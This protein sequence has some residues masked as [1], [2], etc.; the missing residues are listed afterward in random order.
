MVRLTELSRQIRAAPGPD[1]YSLAT[2]LWSGRSVRNAVYTPVKEALCSMAPGRE[3]CMYCGDNHGT[4]VDH[5]EP[6]ARNP[7][8][9]FDWLNHLLACSNCNSHQKRDRFPCDA[10]G[11][12]LLIDPTAEDPADH[13]FLSLSVGEYKALSD[14]GA[15]T[16]EVCDLNRAL[17]A[18]GRM[19]ARRVVAMALRG[20]R[21]DRDAGDAAGMAEKVLTIREQPF[22]DVCQAMLRQATAPG[23]DV[24]FSDSPDLIALLCSEPLREAL[25]A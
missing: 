11:R 20:W 25:L 9:T 18:R 4:D 16:I 21:D 14:K 24:I 13:L 23:A 7:L 2:R 5:F 1:R 12:P 10:D 3:R 19:Q 8:R 15:R 6:V 22:A 17:L